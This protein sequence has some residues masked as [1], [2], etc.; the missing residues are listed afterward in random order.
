LPENKRSR[1]GIFVG[2]WTVILTGIAGG[3]GYGLYT[4]GISAFFKD[5]AAELG[6]SRAVTSLASGLGRLEGGV[7]S[8]LVGWLSDRVGPRWWVVSGLIIAGI[9]MILMRYIGEVWHYFVVWGVLIGI[10][11]NIALTVAVDKALTNWFVRRRGLAQG[12]RFSIL[13]VFQIISLQVITSLVLAHGW[14][15]TCFI[16]GFVML[17]MVPFTL[18]LIKNQRPEYYGMLPDGAKVELYETEAG[19]DMV[20]LGVEY[21]S[22]FDETEFTF[23]QAMK[24]FTYWVLVIALGLQNIIVGG[25]T[26]HIIPF[27]TDKGIDTAIASGMMGM[28]VLFTIPSRL[29][30]GIIAD[31]LRKDRL[32]YLLSGILFL[33]V[34][35]IGAFLIFES[36]ASV[37]ILLA[38]Y[39]LS[40]GGAT[41]LLILMLGRY[42][43]RTAF[44]SILGTTLAIFAPLGLLSPVYCGWVYDTTGSYHTVFVTFVIMAAAS[45]LVTLFIRTPRKP[46]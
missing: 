19:K 11:L 43:G 7:T 36:T 42:Y 4:L 23:R 9:G 18:A 30:G 22:S 27:L 37:Y 29:F 45:A 26:I 24:N 40:L 12:L 38:C 10:G 16:W 39:G 3:T 34:I 41:P 28:M 21:A 2:W 8:P 25:F 15:D 6:L 1:R 13:S 14:R 35:G 31:R 32:K 33:H 46:V 20:G 44:G 5:L 17:A